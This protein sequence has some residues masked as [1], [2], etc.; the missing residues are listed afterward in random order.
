VAAAALAVGIP[1]AL[2]PY[3][4]LRAT[5]LLMIAVLVTLTFAWVRCGAAR[6]DPGASAHLTLWAFALASVARVPLK[7]GPDHYGF[8]LIPPVLVCVALA[9]ALYL[10]AL[11]HADRAGRRVFEGCAVALLAGIAFSALRVSLPHYT[12]DCVDIVTARVHLCVEPDTWEVRTVPLLA[13]LPPGTRGIAIPEGAGLLFAAGVETGADGRT[14]YNPID[15]PDEE[16]DERLVAEWTRSPPDV[17]VW[18]AMNTA[19]FGVK[20]FGYDYG[21]RA[22]AWLYRHYAIATQPYEQVL[23]LVPRAAVQ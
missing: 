8:Y 1:T 21:L 10:P 22:S 4:F 13:S 2:M 3:I 14:S 5:P 12:A 16:A 18:C 17:V 9:M 6:R 19:H 15:V 20:G 23:L 11:V 7:V